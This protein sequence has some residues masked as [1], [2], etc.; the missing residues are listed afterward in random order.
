M[1]LA[2]LNSP[3]LVASLGV[4]L[5]I[6]GQ[7]ALETSPFFLKHHQWFNLVAY[8]INTVAVGIPGRID[9]EVAKGI[10]AEND[11]KKKKND[12][13]VVSSSNAATNS[14]SAALLPRTGKTL[15]APAGWAFAIWGPIFTGELAF[16]ISQFFVKDK[17][18]L[19]SQIQSISAPFVIAQ[20]FQTLWCAAFRPK[21]TGNLMW[22]STGM[23]G[24]V[25]YYLSKAHAVFTSA[26]SVR[27]I[28]GF[29]WWEYAIHFLPI[30][31]HFGWTTAATL[32]NLNGAVAV[33]DYRTS[34]NAL[35][36]VVGHASVVAAT[37]LG[38]AITFSRQAPVY[39]GV[40]SWALFAVADGMRQRLAAS[41]NGNNN[42]GAQRQLILSTAGAYIS[43]LA[44]FA[45]GLMPYWK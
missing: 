28:P 16:V 35:I 9:G 4:A 18:L 2:A 44:S 5:S 19:A 7:A 25:A 40:I 29:S 15:V 31:L 1:S 17:Q 23:L 14:E 20:L 45:A 22:I 38:V 43:G 27:M 30:S 6:Y 13:E 26:S 34:S 42:V 3:P 8:A 10:Q 36:N 32:V 11:A 33:A 37:A 24:G 41:S 39:G 12:D 21:Y